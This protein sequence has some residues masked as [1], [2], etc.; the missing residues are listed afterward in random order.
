MP[1]SQHKSEFSCHMKKSTTNAEGN[2]NVKPHPVTQL[3]GKL[4]A[5]HDTNKLWRSHKVRHITRGVVMY[6]NASKDPGTIMRNNIPT[7]QSM[8]VN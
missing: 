5:K 3:G 6:D 2:F 4:T 1:V 8:N 7:I